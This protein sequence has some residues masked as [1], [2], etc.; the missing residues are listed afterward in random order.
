MNSPQLHVGAGSA[1]GPLT[2]FPVWT[3]APGKLG[4]STGTHADL[5]VSE[6]AGGAVVGR[7]HVRNNGSRAA[8]LLEGEL[9][10]GGQQ[11]RTCARDT[12]LGPGE[13][14]DI[15]T[16][17]VEAGRW[18]TGRSTHRRLARRAPLNVRWELNTRR[19]RPSGERQAR[20]W[21]R[22]GRFDAA[23]GATA[24][25]SLPEHLDRFNL[26]DRDRY[27][28]ALPEPLEGQRGVIIGLAGI[29]LL[30]E[31]FGTATLF[32]RHYR[33]LIDAALLDAQLL[34]PQAP[35]SAAMP[36]QAARD[37][38]AVVGTMQFGDFAAPA[39]AELRHSGGQLRSR[40][41]AAVHGAVTAEGIA[42]ALPNREPAIAHLTSWNTNHPLMEAV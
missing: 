35:S 27:A 14:L 28:Q 30:L 13:S 3:S 6:L 25:N 33:Q 16:F 41:I 34:V 4:I 2:L 26:S 11:H 15:D 42:V 9:L 32:R 22:V 19:P 23:H 5:A 29:P 8:L 37:F 39:A 10:E 38:A 24:T 20:V 31:I 1:I 7:L 18:E 12:I 21:A 17:C 40:T 36:G